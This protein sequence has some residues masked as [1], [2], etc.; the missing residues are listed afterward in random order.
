MC[1]K[2]D[3]IGDVH[4]VREEHGIGYEGKFS[5]SPSTV[6]EGGDIH[7]IGKALVFHKSIRVK[8]LWVRVGNWIMQY[9]PVKE[10]CR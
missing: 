10:K 9:C 7:R 4:D 6:T 8:G 2:A 3:S 5:R 1:E